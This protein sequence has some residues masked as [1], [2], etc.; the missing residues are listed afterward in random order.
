VDERNRR[1]TIRENPLQF[2][3]DVAVIDPGLA[4]Y[5]GVDPELRGDDA[6]DPVGPRRSPR[7]ICLKPQAVRAM[8]D[9]GH[10]RVDIATCAVEPLFVLETPLKQLHA[11]AG[12]AIE[13]Q[14][15]VRIRPLRSGPNQGYHLMLLFL[16]RIDKVAT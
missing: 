2:A 9:A 11:G 8:V 6:P 1:A 15:P 7:K 4:V 13:K 12:E 5:S 10:N 14:A 16:Q 3:L